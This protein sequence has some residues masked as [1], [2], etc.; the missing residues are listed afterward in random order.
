MKISDTP[1]LK[2]LPY[3]TNLALFMVKIWTPL[4]IKILKTQH[5]FYNVGVWE[6]L[7]GS[8]KFDSAFQDQPD[9]FQE[10]LGT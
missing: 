5:P 1:F 6:K 2:P 8:S 3:F 9:E 4:F 7:F 10:F